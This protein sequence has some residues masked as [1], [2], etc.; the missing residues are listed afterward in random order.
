MISV[1][2]FFDGKVARPLEKLS[3][4]SKRKVIITFIDDET[5][6]ESEEIRKM[7][8][9]QSDFDFWNDEEEDIY[10]EYL[11]EK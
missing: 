6:F 9:N 5:D 10:G 3:S 2:G 4:M 1:R 8:L 11:I 7:S